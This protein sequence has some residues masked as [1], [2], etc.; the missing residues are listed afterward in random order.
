[1]FLETVVHIY[2]IPRLT[3]MLQN[4][5]P[6]KGSNRSLIRCNCEDR[7]LSKWE[8]T[9]RQ[10]QKEAMSLT[11]ITQPIVDK[12]PPG[13]NCISSELIS[14]LICGQP[15]I[16]NLNNLP[17]SKLGFGFLSVDDDNKVINNNNNM[18]T[19]SQPPMP[20]WIVKGPSSY[21][22][23][24]N[25]EVMAK[26]NDSKSSSAE[27]MN[28]KNRYPFHLSFWNS[29]Y[30]P[31]AK[32]FDGKVIPDKQILSDIKN[33]SNIPFHPVAKKDLI[34]HEA[35][36]VAGNDDEDMVIVAHP[37]DEKF[38]EDYH[39]WRFSVSSKKKK[40]NNDS[41]Q[42]IQDINNINWTSFF[43]LSKSEKKL[44]EIK[45]S[46]QVNRAIWSLWPDSQI[47]WTP[48][49]NLIT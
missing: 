5:T 28:V 44:V 6:S 35:T 18:N 38:Y 31:A 48:S 27:L 32:R 24:W 33:S 34:L 39:H 19:Q 40:C 9:L 36:L 16:M 14:L 10:Y 15:Q 13:H 25:N 11:S 2:G 37:D 29:W 7:V 47:V 23:L 17:T 30:E 46:P 1:M 26:I 42:G 12:A 21:S 45:M 4:A 20:I 8:V 49:S 43:R 22:V 3:R 41:N